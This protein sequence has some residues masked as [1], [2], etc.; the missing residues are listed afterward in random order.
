MPSRICPD[1]NLP[2]FVKRNVINRCHCKRKNQNF[3]F[4]MKI[5]SIAQKHQKYSPLERY[6]YHFSLL[7]KTKGKSY[8]MHSK[9]ACH[10]MKYCYNE[11]TENDINSMLELKG[12][13]RYKFCS[14]FLYL[15]NS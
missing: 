10:F 6:R 8:S 2:M 13:S 4:F 12:K 11:F 1:C 14:L 9:R 15:I 7:S 5:V 3:P